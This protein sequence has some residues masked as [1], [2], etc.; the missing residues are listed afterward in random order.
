ME[1]NANIACLDSIGG[2]F[3]AGIPNQGSGSVGGGY[4]L[5]DTMLTL[6]LGGLLGDKSFDVA[7]VYDVES[8]DVKLTVNGVDTPM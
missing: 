7:I 5:N 1:L 2:G 4:T 3:N 6:G 8:G